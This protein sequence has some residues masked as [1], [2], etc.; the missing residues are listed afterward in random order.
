M[1]ISKAK[2]SVSNYLSIVQFGQRYVEADHL[3]NIVFGVVRNTEKKKLFL[4]F[5]EIIR[6][7]TQ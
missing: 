1:K 4:A 3:H 2:L 6:K 7:C 5:K